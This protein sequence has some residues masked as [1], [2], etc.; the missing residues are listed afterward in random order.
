V[1]ET[2]AKTIAERFTSIDDLI[3]SDIEQLTAVNEIG[4]KIASSIISFFRDE[5]NVIIINRLKSFG[6]KLSGEARTVPASDKLKGK[7]ILIS[8][9]FQNHTRDEYKEIIKKN[10][11]RNTSSL[12]GNTSFILAGENMGP[13]KKEKAQELGIQMISEDEFLKIINE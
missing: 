10:G 2:V 4:P 6:L 7:T 13:S 3:N 5:D 8:G 1:G 11:G 9:T 12:S